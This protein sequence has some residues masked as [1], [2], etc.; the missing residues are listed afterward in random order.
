MDSTN[1]LSVHT[2]DFIS[3]MLMNDKDRNHIDRIVQAFGP[4]RNEKTGSFADDDGEDGN[5]CP[6]RCR[7][8][9]ERVIPQNSN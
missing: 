5:Y 4:V 6:L 9:A 2:A 3:V 1:Y 8:R 7:W